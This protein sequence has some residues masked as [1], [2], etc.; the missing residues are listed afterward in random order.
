MELE[1]IYKNVDR[2]T[3]SKG[4]ERELDRDEDI[5]VNK[6]QNLSQTEAKAQN[7]RGLTGRILHIKLTAEREIQATLMLQTS[8]RHQTEKDQLQ[9]SFNSLSQKKLELETRVSNLTAEKTQLQ[10]S[11]NALSQKKLELETR[12][13]DLTAEKSQ[14]QRSF[15]SLSQK[16]LQLET[17]LRK[18]SEQG[19]GRFFISN[20]EKSWSDSRKYCRD[21]GGD[22]I[23]IKTEEKQRCISSF[24]KESVW[25]GLSDIE[26]EGNMKWVDNS[27]LKQGFFFPNEPNDAHGNEDCV[28]MQY[29]TYCR[30]SDL[31]VW[32]DRQCSDWKKALCEK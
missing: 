18:I 20:E 8:S 13:K 9:S 29:C 27:P 15:N 2:E 26:N 17:E 23:I 3:C 24:I 11:F 7:Q 25:I 10:N 22:L 19:N 21:R 12:I 28:E 14:L 16:K 5:Y 6:D 4:N 31:N 30:P 1:G 32:N